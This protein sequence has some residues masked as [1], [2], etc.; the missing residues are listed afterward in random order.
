MKDIII[1]KQ[2]LDSRK[3]YII[4]D[5]VNFMNE[6]FNYIDLMFTIKDYKSLNNYSDTSLI[7]AN[8]TNES[9]ISIKDSLIPN[10]VNN[11]YDKKIDQINFNNSDCNNNKNNNIKNNNIK[12]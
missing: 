4:N 3:T 10:L 1:F 9:K 11:I 8:L 6:I 5:I 12:C 7:N 2:Y